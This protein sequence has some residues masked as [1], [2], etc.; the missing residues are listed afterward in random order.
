[1]VFTAG[2]FLQPPLSFSV[3]TG[4]SPCQLPH[5]PGALK[6][7]SHWATSC[8]ELFHDTTNRIFDTVVCVTAAGE[9]A[10]ST[11]AALILSPLQLPPDQQRF[12]VSEL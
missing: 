1:M 6:H 11:H 7:P 10:S 12:P 9:L 4:R 5:N 3:V 2:S 8:S